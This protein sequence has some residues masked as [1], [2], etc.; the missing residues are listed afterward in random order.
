V[1]EIQVRTRLLLQWIAISVGQ[2]TQAAILETKP[3]KTIDWQWHLA[4]LALPK[5]NMAVGGPTASRILS[6]A[7][8][9][10]DQVW[11]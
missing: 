1:S 8:Y 2:T 11:N 4:S 6:S 10:G 9:D 3:P 7:P 5:A